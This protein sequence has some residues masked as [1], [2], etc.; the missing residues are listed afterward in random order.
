MKD[1]TGLVP[2]YRVNNREENLRFFRECL[3]LTVV[4]EEAAM[5]ALAG[6]NDQHK[7]Q[8]AKILLEESPREDGFHAV[9]GLK[10]HART[11]IKADAAEIKALMARNLEWDSRLLKGAAGYAFEALS[12]ERDLFLV[13]AGD[14]FEE[15]TECS[16]WDLSVELT[17]DENFQGLTEIAITEIDLNEA[18]MPSWA[19][20]GVT[21]IAADGE[22]LSASDTWDIE[23][24]DV[25]LAANVDL[26]ALSADFAEPYLDSK[27]QL[28]SVKD[29]SGLELWFEK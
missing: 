1:I 12:P 16:K 15:L 11:V 10:R 28:L 24:L 6:T 9:T 18:E 25:H 3:G 7:E 8:A 14:D 23:A 29:S 13:Y 17:A 20:P 2:V 4:L 22:E 5:V 27:K 26:Q 21:F 19:L